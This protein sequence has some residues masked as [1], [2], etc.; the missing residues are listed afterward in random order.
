MRSGKL[1]VA[2]ARLPVTMTRRTDG[3][4]V[5]TST[6]GLVT[7]LKSVADTRDFTWLG[8]AGT[9]VADSE[10]RAVASELEKHGS[11]AV[12]LTKAEIDGFYA[13][14][15]N[16]VLWPLFHGMTSRVRFTATAWKAYQRVNQSFAEAIARDVGPGDMIW[17]HD[18]QL[19]LVPE[20]LRRL[21]VSSPIGFFLHIPFPST[22]AYRTLPAREEILRG[23]LGADFI[24]FHAYEYVSQF[25]TTCLR[26]LG[27]ESEP[28]VIRL[29]ARRVHLGTLPIG[30]DPNEIHEM[31]KSPEAEAEYEAATRSHRGKKIIVGVDRLD[32]TKGLPEKLLAFE[33]LLRTYPKWRNKAVLIQVAAPSRETVA[34]YVELKRLV[35]EL[36]GRING[37][38]GSASNTPIVYVN[39]SLPRS[40][41]VGLYQAAD[42]ALVTPL[43]DGMNLVALEYI[44]ARGKA[45]GSLILSEFAGAAHLL[46][47]AK[48]VSPYNPSEVASALASALDSKP[49]PLT[50][51]RAFVEGNTAERWAQTFL[52]RLEET[53]AQGPLTARRLRVDEEPAL[54]RLSGAKA[55]LVLLDY[56]G[57]LRGFETNPMDAAPTARIHGVVSDLAKVCRLYIISGRPSDV[58]ERWFG[59]LEIG[60]VSEHGFAVKHAGEEWESRRGVSVGS[61]L[62]RLER[63]FEEFVRRT[64]GSS[65]ERK[66]ASIAWHYRGADPEWGTFQANELYSL[67]EDRV[68]RRSLNVLRGARVI[69][70]RHSS[71]T[72]GHATA[73]LLKRHADCDVLFCAGDDRTDEE[74]ME[75]IPKKWRPRSV[76]CWVGGRNAA[77]EFWVEG[78][79]ALLAELAVLCG[80]WR[81]RRVGRR[82]AAG[83]GR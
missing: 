80:V 56:D 10:Q 42:V 49:D 30:I 69:E 77:A 44:A 74:M 50:H 66:K 41:L 81:T 24:G 8:W 33:E 63:L 39:Q 75:A 36:V 2:S 60:M 58:L 3:W 64:P 59:D 21:G 17:V 31:A 16:R 53:R 70:V 20:M 29:P 48:L 79:D 14:F 9:N 23:L 37:R 67:L 15:S 47:G 43:R 25:R 7:A 68:K 76:M 72:K 78:S 45:G 13:G 55:P 28:D 32:Y 57:T 12:F 4:D 46:A 62:K 22:E 18:Y 82:K 6:G 35:D 34:E 5:R 52:E 83:R 61:T 71:I 65:I 51:M 19:A 27:L 26:V 54:S 38:F 1:I 11:V 40:R 73:E